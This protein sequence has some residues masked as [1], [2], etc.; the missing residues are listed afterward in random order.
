MAGKV[1]KARD[2][3]RDQDG[4]VFAVVELHAPS[5]R[6]D[7]FMCGGSWAGVVAAEDISLLSLPDQEIA[8]AR[9]RAD[10]MAAVGRTPYGAM[11]VDACSGCLGNIDRAL[12][13]VRAKIAELS[14]KHAKIPK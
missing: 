6:A 2:Q 10:L 11:S 13:A 5:Y 12:R 4:R 7:M 3:A 9:A 8:L 1:G 14:A